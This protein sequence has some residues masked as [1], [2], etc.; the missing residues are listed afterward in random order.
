M[1]YYGHN[2]DH[3]FKV[4]DFWPRPEQTHK[5]PFERDEIKSELKRLQE[6]RLALR[7]MRLQ[8]EAALKEQQQTHDEN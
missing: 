5:I 6:K 7:D 8:R 2:L 1:L 4:P 3:K